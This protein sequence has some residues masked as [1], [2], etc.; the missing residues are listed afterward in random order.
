MDPQLCR[1]V[2]KT[3]RL[4][5][6]AD[7]PGC[8]RRR[9]DVHLLLPDRVHKFDLVRVQTYSSVGIGAGCA[10][11]QVA[12]DASS[13]PRQLA[14]DLVVTPGEQLNLD[15][16]ISVRVFQMRVGQSGEFRSGSLLS[17]S[18][19]ETLVHLLVADQP[20]IQFGG[21]LFRG[22][23]AERPIGLVNTPGAEHLRES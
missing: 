6:A 7:F 18:G 19:D 10:V 11:F 22:V 20:V 14:A 9:D 15:Q 16:G 1:S 17:V 12:F 23:A 5:D 13:D 3:V 4:T 21:L 8:R 2:G